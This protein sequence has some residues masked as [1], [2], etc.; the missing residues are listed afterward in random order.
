[1]RAPT[2]TTDT[3]IDARPGHAPA[4]TCYGFRVEGPL[5]FRYLRPGGGSPLTV[6]TAGRVTPPTSDPIRRWIPREGHPFEAD[7][8]REGRFLKLWIKGTGWYV[9]DP[10]RPAILVP[11]DADP[12]R[13]EERTWGFPA[14]LCFTRRGDLP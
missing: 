9:I 10:D 8:Y 3:K 1:M 7:L 14:A 5:A 6:T 11:D 2:R 4:S 13:R 12:V